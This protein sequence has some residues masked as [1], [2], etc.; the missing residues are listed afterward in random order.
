MNTKLKSSDTAT[1][2]QPRRFMRTLGVPLLTALVL[3]MISVSAHSATGPGLPRALADAAEYGENI[4]DYAQVA[5]WKGANVALASLKQSLKQAPALA[6]AAAGDLPSTVTSLDHAITTKDAQA[7]MRAANQVT[8]EVADASAAFRLRVP[9]QVAR[10]DYYGRELE[11][12]AQ[13]Q[14]LSKLQT[15]A[16]ALRREWEALRP[17]LELRG[18][19][20]IAAGKRFETLVEQVAAAKVPAEYARLSK[21]VLDEVDNLEKAFQG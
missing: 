18:T 9:V 2:T 20:G 19:A 3:E 17:T 8:L 1:Q 21:S 4:Y 16:V 13:A 14:D 11:I 10:L 6:Q 5:N 12:W 7:A 15:T